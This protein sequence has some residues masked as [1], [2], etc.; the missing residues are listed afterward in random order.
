MI[1]KYTHIIYIYCERM[2]VCMQ[3]RIE[4]CEIKTKITRVVLARSN[5]ATFP[6]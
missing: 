3:L 5:M 4:L 1:L 6:T 2:Y